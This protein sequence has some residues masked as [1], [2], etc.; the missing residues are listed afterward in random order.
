MNQ[1]RPF[2]TALCFVLFAMVFVSSNMRPTTLYC[3]AIHG[4]QAHAF[5]ETVGLEE[6]RKR[7]LKKIGGP[8]A[9]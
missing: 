7:F 4:A 9:G 6:V 8:G 2:L 5:Y 1:P 3:E